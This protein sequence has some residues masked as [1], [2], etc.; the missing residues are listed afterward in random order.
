MD[1]QESF[2]PL[3]PWSIDLSQ[4]WGKLKPRGLVKWRWGW[5]SILYQCPLPSQWEL[6]Q[7]VKAKPIQSPKTLKAEWLL[8]VWQVYNQPLASVNSLA[9]PACSLH[10]V[11]A[12]TVGTDLHPALGVGFQPHSRAETISVSQAEVK[13]IIECPFG[14]RVSKKN[15]F[16]WL[17][18][19]SQGAANP[20]S[21]FCLTHVPECSWDAEKGREGVDRLLSLYPP[22]YFTYAA[23]SS[24]LT[25]KAKGVS[26]G[27]SLW[28]RR[29]P[30]S[31]SAHPGTSFPEPSA[32]RRHWGRLKGISLGNPV[33]LPLPRPQQETKK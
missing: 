33:I 31:S 1:F 22:P 25:P 15:V 24:L 13:E 28:R 14:S 6:T 16:G 12:Q 18:P 21:E 3:E 19:L 10:S 8:R 20:F 2:L 26:S 23:L 9:V 11:P 17:L 30:F 29:S 32:E 4:W 7:R 27:P 5:G